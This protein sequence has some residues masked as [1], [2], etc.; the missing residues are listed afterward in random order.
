MILLYAPTSPYVRKVLVFAHETG[1][2]ADIELQTVKT[3]PVIRQDAIMAANPLGK[4]PTLVLGDGTALFDSRVI[5]EY[6]DSCHDG[7]ALFPAAGAARWQMLRLQA[8][9]DGIL[10]AGVAHRYETFLRPEA[11]RWA[12]WIEG[13]KQKIEAVLDALEAAAQS[14][15]GIDAGAIAIGCALGYLDFRL[16]DL[17][18]RENRPGLAAWFAAFAARPSMQA[19]MPAG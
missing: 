6:L 18:W 19:T 2:L 12:D 17:N 9:A 11:Y 8:M 4:I 13:Q 14:L 1:V 15:P 16:A 7:A 10:D 5:C 3:S